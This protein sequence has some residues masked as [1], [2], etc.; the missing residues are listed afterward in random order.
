MA[1]MESFAKKIIFHKSYIKQGKSTVCQ[2]MISVSTVKCNMKSDE[3][4]LL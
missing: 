3:R 2:R 4:G 1:S